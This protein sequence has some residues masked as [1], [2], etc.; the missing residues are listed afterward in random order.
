MDSA[1]IKIYT[2]NQTIIQNQEECTDRVIEREKEISKMIDKLIKKSIEPKY[3]YTPKKMTSFKTI[4]KFD[5][6]PKVAAYIPETN[7]TL[8]S[9]LILLQGKIREH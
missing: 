7:N 5:S 1:N 9:D 8:I 6:L 2:L 3:S 4:D